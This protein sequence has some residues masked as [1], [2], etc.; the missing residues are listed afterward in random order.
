MGQWKRK[1]KEAAASQECSQDEKN[2]RLEVG[3]SLSKV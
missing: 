2:Q 1:E 3:N